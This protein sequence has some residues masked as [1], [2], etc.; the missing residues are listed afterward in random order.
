MNLPDVSKKADLRYFLDTP[1]FVHQVTE[2]IIMQR[3]PVD[4]MRSASPLTSKDV[5]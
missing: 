2:N 1:V 5:F 4:P 3:L